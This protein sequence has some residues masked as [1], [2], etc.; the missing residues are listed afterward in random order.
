MKPRHLALGAALLL[1]AGLLAF[2]DNAPDSGIAEPSERAATAAPAAPAPGRAPSAGVAG[3]A[4]EGEETRIAR[5]IPRATL[6]GAD[7]GPDAAAFARQDWTPPPEPAPP[8][9]PPPP[10]SAPPLPFTFIGKSLQDG[11]WQVYL[12]RGERAY[13]VR[14]KDVIDGAYRVDA[15]KPPVLTLTYLPL[16]QVQQL[17]IGVFD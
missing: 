15:I 14:D 5:L 9:P 3:A 16:N 4:G 13:L 2:G 7:G 1:A 17:N 6:L 8:P 11:V 10:P 12:A